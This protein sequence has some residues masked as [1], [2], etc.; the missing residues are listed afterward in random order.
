[1]IRRPERLEWI[2]KMR[3]LPERP[4]TI[5]IGKNGWIH[6]T[7][8]IGDEGIT[9]E[10]DEKGAFVRCPNYGDVIIGDNV[11][12]GAFTTVR[13]ATLPD[14]ATIVGEGSI[15]LSHVTISHNAKIGKHNF[16]GN[17]V[18][19]DGGVETGNYCW[20][21]PHAA[22][23]GHV[24]IGDK[25]IVGMGA[26]VVKDIPSDETVVGIP[27]IPIRF[28]GNYIHPSFAYGENLK[29]GKYNHI[30]EGVKVGNNTT[31]RSYVEL[32][33]DIIIG[34]N[35]YIDSGVKFSGQN[36][37]GNNVKIEENATINDG[38]EIGEKVII[39]ANA[40]VNKDCLELGTYIGIPAKRLKR[41]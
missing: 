13:R 33:K 29:I 30:H 2:R 8:S 37:I 7:A 3:N 5:I 16:I 25:A 24:K 38:V 9:A 28:A 1:M 14:V 11:R 22:I 20:I 26:V 4:P 18:Q 34:D 23:R 10:R 27:A 35:C 15:L 21:A 6:P 41:G 32:R 36:N 17:H 19:I 12:I 40:F 39:G 31:I